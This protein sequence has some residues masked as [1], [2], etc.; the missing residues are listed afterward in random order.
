MRDLTKSMLSYS[1]AMSLFGVQ[2]MWN[3]MSPSRATKA[4]DEVTDATEE[5]FGDIMQATFRTGDNIQRM[6]VDLTLGAFSGQSSN[7]NQWTRA[8]ADAMRQSADV[9]SQGMQGA[10]NTAWQ[11]ANVNQ[12]DYRTNDRTN[13]RTHEGGRQRREERRDSSSDSSRRQSRGWGFM[14]CGTRDSDSRR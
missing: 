14:P 11:A 6:L 8:T 12:Q 5:Q 1:W 7:S 3:L 9:M 2:Q 13:D 10:A 4:F